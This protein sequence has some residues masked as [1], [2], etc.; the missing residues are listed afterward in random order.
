V[1]ISLLLRMGKKIPMEGVTE[2]NFRVETEG[3]TMQKLP[4]PP[5]HAFHIQPPNPD[6]VAFARTIL[7]TG[8]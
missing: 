1:D 8:H 7:L 5:R 3:E 6:T 2:T 4:P